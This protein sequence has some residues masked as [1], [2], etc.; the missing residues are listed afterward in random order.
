MKYVENKNA[1]FLKL[2]F[3]EQQYIAIFLNYPNAQLNDR[4]YI[5]YFSEKNHITKNVGNRKLYPE[6][7]FRFW[8]NQS[9]YI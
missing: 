7:S 5:W 4:H 1:N 3:M 6:E 8:E 2:H 9:F